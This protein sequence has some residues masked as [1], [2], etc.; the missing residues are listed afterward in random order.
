[1]AGSVNPQTCRVVETYL[2]AS[3]NEVLILPAGADGDWAAAL[4]A[5]A[6][7][8]GIAGILVQSPDFFGRLQDLAA[9]SEIAHQAG[10]L[11]IASCDLLSLAVLRTPGET[12]IDI[13]VGETQSL[14]LPLSF[15]GPYAGYLAARDSLLRRMPGRICGETADRQGRRAFVLTIQAREQHIRRD[16]ATSNI[17]T[18]EGALRLVRHN[19]RRDAGWQRPARSGRAIG[20]QGSGPAKIADFHRL[21]FRRR[22]PPVLPRIRC[23]AA[24]GLLA[25]ATPASPISTNFWPIA[26]SSAALTFQTLIRRSGLTEAGCWP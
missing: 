9:V 18:N 16:K 5:S 15:G 24:A 17:C 12:G 19:P 22:F 14:G 20:I 6:P 23:S 13:A 26:A 21:V 1:M 3:G 7:D 10:A 2:H 4:A 8:G 25:G 11:A